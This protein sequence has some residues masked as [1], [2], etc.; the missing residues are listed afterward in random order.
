MM[1]ILNQSFLKA[2]L[3]TCFPNDYILEE[4]LTGAVSSCEVTRANSRADIVVIASELTLV[5]EVKVDALEGERQCDA[6][7]TRHS[8]GQ[9]EAPIGCP[10]SAPPDRKCA[11]PAAP[12]QVHRPRLVLRFDVDLSSFPCDRSLDCVKTMN[13]CQNSRF[14]TR[15]PSSEQL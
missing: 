1:S 4:E 15:Q 2:V 12:R 11:N 14:V 13:L 8:A 6:G 5:V 10:R 3:R 9:S 7:P